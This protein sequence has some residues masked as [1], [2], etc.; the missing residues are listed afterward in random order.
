M[1]RKLA[2][3]TMLVL[4][5]AAASLRSLEVAVAQEAAK[6]PDAPKTQAPTKE[7][8]PATFPA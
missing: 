4:S 7:E 1:T 6:A 3:M 5:L 2:T 8:P